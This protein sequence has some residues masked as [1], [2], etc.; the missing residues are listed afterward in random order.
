MSTMSEYAPPNVVGGKEL[1]AK[2][3]AVNEQGKLRL[4]PIHDLV[5]RPTRPVPH[6]DGHV[7]EVARASWDI[8]GG[9]VVQ[10]HL[11]TTFAGRHRAWGLHQRST[12]RL[13]VVSGLGQDRRFR[14]PSRFANLWPRQRLH[15]K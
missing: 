11:T 12:D 3:S 10:V 15:R 9:P 2:Q 14:R 4:T 1:V 5:F 7:T 8:I 13:F 6:E